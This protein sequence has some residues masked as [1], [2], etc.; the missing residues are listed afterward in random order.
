MHKLGHKRL[1]DAY[2]FAVYV[3][4]PKIEGIDPVNMLQLKSLH[5]KIGIE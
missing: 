5:Q 3:K 1:M 2:N 4:L